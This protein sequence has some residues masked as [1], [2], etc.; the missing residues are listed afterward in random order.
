[1][2][3]RDIFYTSTRENNDDSLTLEKLEESI[4][5]IKE[6]KMPTDVMAIFFNGELYTIPL[7][8][9]GNGN[10]IASC[11]IGMKQVSIIVS[12]FSPYSLTVHST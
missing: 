2:N 8:D 5:L 10:Q 1:M 12:S 7:K 4:A 6:E 9:I 11:R 3:Y